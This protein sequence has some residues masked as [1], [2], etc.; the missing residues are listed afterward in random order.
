VQGAGRLIGVDNG[1]P[2][3]HEDFEAAERRAFDG[4]CLAIV[5]TGTVA[6]EI[7]VTVSAEGLKGA[8]GVLHTDD[9][10]LPPSGITR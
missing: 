2:A 5:Q 7:R 8:T 6:G 4:R 1:N 3:S 10:E 9:V